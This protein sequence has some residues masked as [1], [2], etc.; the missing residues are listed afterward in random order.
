M[1]RNDVHL[2]VIA[3]DRE[4]KCG[5]V[6]LL[7]E[8]K[9]DSC[10]EQVGREGTGSAIRVYQRILDLNAM[11]V[12]PRRV[13]GLNTL[14]LSSLIGLKCFALLVTSSRLFSAAVAAIRASPARR[15]WDMAYSSMYMSAR[16]PMFSESGNVTN[17]N[18][19][20]KPFM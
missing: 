4:R 8:M 3:D 19:D 18:E 5:I 10:F 17:A 14:I 7:S 1:T 11:R 16:C 2:T 20:R 9:K 15:P 13:Q 6:H 12:A